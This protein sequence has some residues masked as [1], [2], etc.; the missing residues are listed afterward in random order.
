VLRAVS[1]GTAPKLPAIHCRQCILN[2]LTDHDLQNEMLSLGEAGYSEVTL[3]GQNVDAYGR[4]LPGFAPDGAL[5]Q[6]QHQ[7]STRL[8]LAL[9]VLHIL[10]CRSR[11]AL[12]NDLACMSGRSRWQP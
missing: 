10:G 11:G 12:L 6:Q 2:Q 7:T 9:L 3:L 8:G 5:L 4:D 1:E